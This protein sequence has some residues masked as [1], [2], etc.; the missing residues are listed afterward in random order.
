MTELDDMLDATYLDDLGNRSL[1]DIRAMRSRC[2]EVETSLSYFRRMVQGRLD[3]VASE[4]KHRRRGE[5]AT[6]LPDLIG[7]LPEILSEHRGPG[8]TGRLPQS[9]DP[10]EPD[11]T[12]VAELDELASAGRLAELPGM[13]DDE[14]AELVDGLEALEQRVSGR[15]RQL[16]DRIDTLQADLTRRYQSGEASV[17]TLLD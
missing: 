7:Q 10:P 4:R 2:I 13:S 16:F 5:A 15:R 17:E 8:G 3:I 14:I 6:D 9:L 11:P 12:L 1:E